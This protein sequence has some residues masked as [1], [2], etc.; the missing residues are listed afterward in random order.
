[1]MNKSIVIAEQSYGEF[2]AGIKSSIREA[3]LHAGRAVNRELIALYWRI[4]EEIVQRQERHAWGRSVVERLAADL[5]SEF[6]GVSGFSTPNLWFMRQMFLEYRDRSNLLQLVREIPWGQ[7]IT[8]M[9]KIKEPAAREYYLDMT[10]RMGWSRNVLLNQIKTQAYERHA[11]APKQHNFAATLPEHLA[12]QADEALKDV[13]ML[14]FLGIGKPVVEREMERR[15]INRI[16]DVLLEL[17]YGFSFIGNQFRVVLKEKEYFIDLLFYHRK[18][19]CLVAIELKSGEFKPEYAGKMNFY[20]N[21]LDDFA[22]EPDENPSIGII[23]CA[24]RDRV[25]VEYSLRNINRPVGVSEY[26][27]TA[28]LPRE[29]EGKLPEAREIEA[30]I[31]REMGK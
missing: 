9:T 31:L 16:R 4:G 11:L 19:K 1:M 3:R 25:E 7:N 17:G 8:I 2:L 27:L 13:Y 12:A 6:P 20:L 15:M 18:L 24:Q 30:G 28:E 22:R 10:A 5:R 29:L 23:L 26:T 21:I 14:D